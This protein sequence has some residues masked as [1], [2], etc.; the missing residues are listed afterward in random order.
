MSKPSTLTEKERQDYSTMSIENLRA[1]LK[2]SNKKRQFE[3]SREINKIIKDKQQSNKENTIQPILQ[4]LDEQLT[5]CFEEYKSIC[6]QLAED[7]TQREQ[8][9]RLA[10]DNAF[11]EL[12]E[13]QLNDFTELEIQRGLECQKEHNRQSAN[14]KLLTKVSEW[15]ADRE[16][17][18]DA[19]DMDNEATKLNETEAVK[20]VESQEKKY[21]VLE[22]NL[23]RRFEREFQLLEERLSNGLATLAD[24]KESEF[25]TQ[26]KQCSCAVQ[27]LL[28]AAVNDGIKKIGKKDKQTEITTRVTNFVKKR[29]LE[30]GMNS[31]LLFDQ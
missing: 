1:A 15:L 29:A 3:R 4:R 20:R 24:Q 11:L 13:K 5:E 7:F 10:I 17:Y 14:V 26:Q 28:L 23:L 2:E 6:Q 12:K 25:K 16:L 19:I 18:D 9:H 31:K 21:S 8:Y 27:R 22:A 30:F